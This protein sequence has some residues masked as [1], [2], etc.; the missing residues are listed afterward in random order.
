M[1]YCKDCRHYIGVNVLARI[2]VPHCGKV[3]NIVGEPSICMRSRMDGA[4]GHEG[5]LWEPS[6][7]TKIHQWWLRLFA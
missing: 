3:L 4:C 2:H 6:M 7:L 1:K 5:K